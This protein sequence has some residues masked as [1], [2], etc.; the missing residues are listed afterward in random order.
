MERE[1]LEISSNPK[2][3]KLFSVVMMGLERKNRF[4]R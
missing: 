4:Q 3:K 2:K 1:Q